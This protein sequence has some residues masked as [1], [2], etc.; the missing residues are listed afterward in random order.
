MWIKIA[1]AV[2]TV[3]LI[4]IIAL[5]I[6]VN[7]ESVKIAYVDSAKLM[8]KSK[9]IQALQ[10]QLK[11]DSDKSSANLDSLVAE[12]EGSMKDYEKSLSKMSVK[13][14]QLAQ[15]LLQTKQNQLVQYQQAIK[16]KTSQDEQT[17][18]QEVLKGIN[19][20]ISEYGKKNG[21]KVILATSNGNIAYADTAID[22]TEEVIEEI[23]K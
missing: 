17:R 1:V 8:D 10:K 20:Y 15:Q 18:L 13:E 16:Q 22:I 11:L 9:A 7:S 23:N 12:F 21:Y 19:V 3:A 4:I 2:Q 14:K 5:I 6:K